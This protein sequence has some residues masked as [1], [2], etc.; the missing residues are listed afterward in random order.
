MPTPNDDETISAQVLRALGDL[1]DTMRTNNQ[2][3]DEITSSLRRDFWATLA[4]IQL[5]AMQHRDEHTA[6]QN[7][8]TH[9]QTTYD[10]WMGALTVLGLINLLLALYLATQG[11]HG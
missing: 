10:R 11:A 4:K 8:R 2:R 1:S 9:R 6:D 7:E 5:D 3:F